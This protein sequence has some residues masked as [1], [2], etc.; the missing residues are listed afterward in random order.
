MNNPT[1]LDD[2]TTNAV[3]LDG[4]FLRF[5][6]HTTH[7]NQLRTLHRSSRIAIIELNQHIKAKLIFRFENI[8]S[9][10]GKGVLLI[11]N[12]YK[13]IASWYRHLKQG[14][15]SDTDFHV[16]SQGKSLNQFMFIS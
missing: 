16:A 11:R 9:Y 7:W 12:P 4:S 10:G 2:S 8:L 1:V 5:N 3:Y 13:A 15:H 14:V 6:H